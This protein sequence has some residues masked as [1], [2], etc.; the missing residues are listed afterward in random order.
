MNNNSKHTRR[1]FLKTSLAVGTIA[2]I[3]PFSILGAAP[4]APSERISLGF[5]GLGRM[6]RS[7]II[8]NFCKRPFVQGLAVCDVDTT[9][10]EYTQKKLN[11]INAKK[12][13]IATS[14]DVATYNDYRKILERDDIDAV[15]ISTPDHWHAAITIEALRAGKDVYCEKPLTHTPN[16]A[17][18]VMDEVKKTGRILQTGSW[19]RSNML[20]FRVA[21]ELVVNGV[22]GEV[23]H[24]KVRFGNPPRACNLLAEDVEPGLD[25][26][27]WIGPAPMR[28]Y[29]SDLCPRGVKDISPKW[30][31]FWEYGG[32][33][34][35]D[36]GAHHVDIARWGMQLD[37]EM[38]FEIIAPE[39]PKSGRGSKLVFANGMTITHAVDHGPS[40]EFLGE[41]G[42]KI[43]VGRGQFELWRGSDKRNREFG[44]DSQAKLADKR[45]LTGDK[46]KQLYRCTDHQ[47]D[48]LDAIK[49]RKRPICNEDIGGRTAICCQLMNITY[50]YGQT[51]KWDAVKN[52]F[53]PNG[54]DPKW[55]GK[56]Y[57]KGYEL[58]A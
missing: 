57:R 25:W 47:Q 55:L 14:N 22:I 5:I 42:D 19:Q 43:C 40:I 36:F 13:G 51:L 16:E 27:R 52:T 24:A 12:A 35:M 32:G 56:Q 50:R 38:P 58:P 1:S 10:R 6:G 31:H 18:A 4:T 53:S 45:Y 41:K 11:E 48:F 26:E 9:R 17:L 2:G 34:V 8:N 39:N 29:H 3:A 7:H 33:S 23:K 20:E 49:S 37:D 28:P 54:G 46:V 30:R 44:S 15:V 21:C